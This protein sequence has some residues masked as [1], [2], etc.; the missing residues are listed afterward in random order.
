MRAWPFVVI[1]MLLLEI[2]WLLG[3]LGDDEASD[4]LVYGSPVVLACGAVLGSLVYLTA[5][6]LSWLARERQ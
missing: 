4:S 6:W 3:N 2:P 5:R 1:G